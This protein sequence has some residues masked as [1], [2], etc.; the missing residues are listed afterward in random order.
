MSSSFKKFFI[1]YAFDER[2]KRIY[3]NQAGLGEN[4]QPYGVAL[5]DYDVLST[6][7]VLTDLIHLTSSCIS[8]LSMS[9]N[10]NDK[11]VESLSPSRGL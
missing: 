6:L 4:V 3:G 9:I 2:D 1:L 11:H 5:C 8:S 7:R 10:W